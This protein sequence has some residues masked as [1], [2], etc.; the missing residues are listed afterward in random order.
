M[1]MKAVFE[2]KLTDTWL[3]GD[4][5]R[6]G[7]KIGDIRV[8]GNKFY[9]CVKFFNDTATLA[10]VAGDVVNYHAETGHVTNIVSGV[11]AEAGTQRLCAG[12]QVAAAI[13]G[14]ENVAYYGWVQVTGSVTLNTDIGGSAGDGDPLTTDGAADLAMDKA[15]TIENRCGSVQDDTAQLVMLQCSF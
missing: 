13:A 1:P 15:A 9:K 12:V 7:D 3:V 6:I 11:V 5:D 14:V 10:S 8:E 4:V 2:T